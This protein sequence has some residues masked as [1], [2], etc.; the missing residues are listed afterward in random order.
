MEML[1]YYYVV[2]GSYIASLPALFPDRKFMVNSLWLYRGA[3]WWRHKIPDNILLIDSGGYELLKHKHGNEYP[4]PPEVYAHY[5]NRHPE[6]LFVSMD[7]PTDTLVLSPEEAQEKTFQNSLKLHELAKG[8]NLIHVIHGENP[9]Q[10]LE[11]YH[12]YLDARLID[13]HS[14]IGMG[15][16][17]KRLSWRFIHKCLKPIYDEHRG[18]I[19][20]FGLSSRLA[21]KIALKTE[22]DS[23]SYD[24]SRQRFAVIKSRYER[25]I[26]HKTVTVRVPKRALKSME[27]VKAQVETAFKHVDFINES[28]ERKQSLIPYIDVNGA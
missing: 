23:F 8:D 11:S 4:F 17:C 5:M 21:E 19:H 3:G 22:T 12:R 24:N 25:W 13:R 15:N 18:R 2:S 1:D 26:G 27:I 14:L 20:I 16:L 6:R 28:L 7:Y 9:G 10:F